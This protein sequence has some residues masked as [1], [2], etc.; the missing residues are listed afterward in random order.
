MDCIVGVYGTCIRGGAL[1]CAP[2]GYLAVRPLIF[3]DKS[4]EALG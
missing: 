2:S 3:N 1:L 4:V